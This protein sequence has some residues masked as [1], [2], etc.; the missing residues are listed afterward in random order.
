MEEIKINAE[1]WKKEESTNLAL[2]THHRFKTKSDAISFLLTVPD[3]D[4][5]HIWNMNGYF[6]VCV[7]HEG[8]IANFRRG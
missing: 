2:S 4:V 3:L 7:I 1:Q 5:A 8:T 6:K